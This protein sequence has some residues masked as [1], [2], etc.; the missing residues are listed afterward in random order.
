MLLGEV[1][2]ALVGLAA[3]GSAC[4]HVGIVGPQQLAV[5]LMKHDV[6]ELV[7]V[8]L[9]AASFGEVV[10][11]HVG[12]QELRERGVGWV[13][14]V[15]HQH[16][17][18]GVHEGQRGVQDAFLGADEGLD[19]CLGVEGDVVPT[20]VERGHGRAQFGYADGGLVAVGIGLA[21][22][23]T[24]HVNGALR[25]WH[26]GAADGEGDD[27]LALGVQLC[28]LLQLAAEVVFL[29]VCQ[30]VGRLECVHHI[31]SELCV[32]NC[33]IVNCPIVQLLVFLTEIPLLV[34]SGTL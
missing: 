9:P 4:R 1:D 22:F 18:A 11:H 24:K 26:V 29:D 25:G 10:A 8:G 12:A 21:G 23:F 31:L 15:G 6:L 19:L 2:E 7:E 14:R 27:V 5:R 32:M 33:Q 3:R 17:V 16:R 30:S 13:A 34:G 20:L 28:H